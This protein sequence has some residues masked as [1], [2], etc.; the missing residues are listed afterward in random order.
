[1]KNLS[2][3]LAFLSITVLIACSHPLQ[4][5]G[6]RGGRGHGY[7]LCPYQCPVPE[8]VSCR[9]GTITGKI[10]NISIEK[11]AEDMEPGIGFNVMEA[12]GNPVHVH[13]GPLWF[14][15]QRES[16]FQL[17]DMVTIE[18]LCYHKA[19]K[20]YLVAAKMTHN[21]HTLKLRDAQGRPY[22]EDNLAR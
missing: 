11:F 13:V 5:Y 17:G 20:Q 22:W 2:V 8:S 21:A 12:D 6:V 18:G 16:D 9:P 1:M 10:T 14:L 4:Q 3:I 7:R 15:E 19:G